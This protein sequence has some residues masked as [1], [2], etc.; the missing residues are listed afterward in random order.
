MGSGLETAGDCICKRD[1][2]VATVASE[3]C[4]CVVGPPPA[5]SYSRGTR[6]LPH[7]LTSFNPYGINCIPW[8][9]A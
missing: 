5:S 8:F 3:F 6:A 7:V 4:A 2:L 9:L 1:E